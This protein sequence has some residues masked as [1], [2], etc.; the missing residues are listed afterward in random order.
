[1]KSNKVISNGYKISIEGKF[2]EILD[3]L[4]FSDLKSLEDLLL[5]AKENDRRDIKDLIWKLSFLG[6]LKIDN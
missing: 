4:Y 3:C 6:V 5:L 1:M 2:K